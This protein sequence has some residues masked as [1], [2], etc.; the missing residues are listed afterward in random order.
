MVILSVDPGTKELGWAIQSN[1]TLYD[2]G[3][4]TASPKKLIDARF[5]IIYDEFCKLIDKAKEFE[6]RL[7]VIERYVG[8]ASA[9]SDAV[10]GL[11]GI[12]RL[13]AKQKDL[14]VEFVV[15]SEVKLIV[16]GY[17]AAGKEMI[18]AAVRRKFPNS[19]I[20]D[21]L[22]TTDAI[23]IGMTIFKRIEERL[24]QLERIKSYIAEHHG[25]INVKTLRRTGLVKNEPE[26]RERMRELKL[27]YKWKRTRL[28]VQFQL[29]WKENEV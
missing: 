1:Q 27:L 10:K 13:A 19:R 5:L 25:E 21:N 7:L 6:C 20:I 3:I 4:I 16:T 26:A 9:G 24:A 18:D 29:P 15:P 12:L 17:G 28:G 14:P 23:A 11:I 8:K 22:N 2:C